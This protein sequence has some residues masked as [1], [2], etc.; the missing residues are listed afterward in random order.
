M[1]NGPGLFWLSHTFTIL[2]DRLSLGL[3][4]E[5]VLIRCIVG[6]EEVVTSRKASSPVEGPVLDL[7]SN[8]YQMSAFTLGHVP[9][10]YAYHMILRQ[11]VKLSPFAQPGFG[12]LWEE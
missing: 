9:L 4:D 5:D 8:D 7:R 1:T 10:W 11:A 12:T 2:V 3:H 6:T